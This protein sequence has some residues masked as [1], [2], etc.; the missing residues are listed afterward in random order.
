MPSAVAVIA[1]GAILAV[2]M[3]LAKNRR[4]EGGAYDFFGAGSAGH[5][6]RPRILVRRRHIRTVAV[7]P[8][9][10]SVLVLGGIVLIRT[11]LSFS[12]QLEM[13]ARAVAAAPHR[14]RR[15]VHGH[16]AD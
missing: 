9:G 12:L 8:T 11:F 3:T 5:S 10:E 14:Q 1:G 13:T 2:F 15:Q 6:S 16:S 4:D 7:T